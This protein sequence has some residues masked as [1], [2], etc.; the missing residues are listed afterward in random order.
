MPQIVAWNRT[1]GQK[2][3]VPEHWVG[4]TVAGQEF[5]KTPRQKAEETKK[6]PEKPAKSAGKE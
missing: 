5:A 1:T 6:S 4:K 2:Q 3:T